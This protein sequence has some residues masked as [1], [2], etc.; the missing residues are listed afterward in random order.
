MDVGDLWLSVQLYMYTD[1]CNGTDGFPKDRQINQFYPWQTSRTIETCESTIH[2]HF[3]N[4]Q[5]SEC[6]SF[7]S[8]Q[9]KQAGR[10]K[11]YWI[12]KYYI[13]YTI[14]KFKHYEFFWIHA[15]ADPCHSRLH[16]LNR[17]STYRNATLIRYFVTTKFLHHSSVYVHIS[18]VSIYTCTS[19]EPRQNSSQW[20]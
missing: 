13:K 10:F 20:I 11:N 1:S 6:P 3:W 15:S 9:Q 14:W 18:A 5:W 4:M 16:Q 7:N 19:A 8:H 2:K 12:I 17:T